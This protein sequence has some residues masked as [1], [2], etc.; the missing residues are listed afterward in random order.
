MN[1][2]EKSKIIDVIIILMSLLTQSERDSLIYFITPYKRE[3]INFLTQKT[4]TIEETQNA[5]HN[6][7]VKN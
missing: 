2:E 4:L 3:L 6:L 1:E 7:S 5:L